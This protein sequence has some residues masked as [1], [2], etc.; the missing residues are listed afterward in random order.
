TAQNITSD[1]TPISK[2]HHSPALTAEFTPLI[3]PFLYAAYATPCICKLQLF[4]HV[5][6]ISFNNPAVVLHEFSSGN[7]GIST[8]QLL[9]HDV[10]SFSAYVRLLKVN[11]PCSL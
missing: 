6:A 11:G 5:L 1:K 9:T 8:G 10:E 7:F 4:G 3:L 2:L